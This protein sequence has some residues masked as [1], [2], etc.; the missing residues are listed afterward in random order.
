MTA[1]ELIEASELGTDDGSRSDLTTEDRS[2]RKP[3]R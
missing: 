2:R 3:T 1:T